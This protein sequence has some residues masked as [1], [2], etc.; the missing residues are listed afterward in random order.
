LPE[1][2]KKQF[3]MREI[4]ARIVDGSRFHEYQPNYGKTLI[5]GFANLW[6]WKIGLLANYGVLFNDSSLK[7]AHF[8][9][10]C[11]QNNTPLAGRAEPLRGSCRVRHSSRVRCRSLARR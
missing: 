8:I 9:E 11:N 1:D 3:D 2:I 4:I 6:G 7:G 5:C 10:L